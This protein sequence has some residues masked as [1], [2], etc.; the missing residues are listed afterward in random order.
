MWT[1][2]KYDFSRVA[3]YVSPLTFQGGLILHQSE[4][5]IH[6]MWPVAARAERCIEDRWWDV[7]DQLSK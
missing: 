2:K 7:L 5:A 6:D 4:A 3:I 1:E